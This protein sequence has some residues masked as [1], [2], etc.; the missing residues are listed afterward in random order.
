MA[1]CLTGAHHMIIILTLKRL[2]QLMT[3]D[4][5]NMEFICTRSGK[6]LGTYR[7]SCFRQIY[8]D[9][10]WYDVVDLVRLWSGTVNQLTGEA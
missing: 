7:S 3:Y 1:S 9:G 2:K 5:I 6:V 4:P 8:I 10:V